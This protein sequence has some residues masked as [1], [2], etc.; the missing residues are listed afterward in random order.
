MAPILAYAD[1]TK[2]FKL[3]TDACGT[4]LGAVLYQTREDGT[5]AVIAYASRS[6]NKAESHYPAHK[7]EFLTLKWA[8]VEK[9]HE[10]LYGSTFDVHTDNNL[11][12]YILT[13]AKLDAASHHWVAS[14]A[15]YNFRLHYRSGKTNINADALSRVSWPECMPDNLGTSLKVNAAAIRAIQEAALDQ[16][17]CPIE[18]YSY[19]LHV[20][21]AIQDSQQVAQM[22]LDDWRQAQ[23]AD[24][25]LGT[26]IER[27]KA[28][29]LDQDWCKQTNSPKLN[30]F[31]RERNNL[32]LQ[33]G[34]LYRQA[35]P[36]ELDE[37]LLQLVLPPAYREVALKGCHDEVGHLGLEHMLDL[38]RD[39]FFWPHMAI[40]MK[41]HIG[42]CCPCLA[43]KARQPKAPLKNIMATHPLELVHLDFLCLEPGKGQEENVLVITDHFTRY[44]QAYVTRTQ[45]AP[46]MAKTLWDKFIVHYGLPKKILT[47][48][49]RNFK[50]QL[51]A[52]LCELMGVQKIWTSPY[53]LQTNGQCE[54]FNSTLI[55]ILG[56]L[57][58]EKK[59]EWKNHVGTLV[60][61]YNC[62]R[63]SATGFS[64]YY[65]MFGRQPHLPVDVALGLAP[66][67]IT[68]PNTAKFVQKL[69]EQNK[70]AHEKAKAFQ[71]KEAERHKRN[72][73]KKGRAVA[74]EV[75]DM[76]LV[77]VTAFK[78]R[79]KMQDRWENREY[80]VEKWPYPDLPVYV[81]CP[82]DG[83]GCS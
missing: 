11:L 15:N 80:V 14:L 63:N 25:A 56:T 50:S 33:K 65:L 2:P 34:I 8:V 72:Y 28:G 81:V 43:F 52:D 24:P 62:T 38:M 20:I 5:E 39:R 27:L 68:E 3:H 77:H 29:V 41:E 47:D 59:S 16:P 48:Q 70:W 19:D 83:E 1:F 13:T 67:T 30:Q 64:P 51:V 6:L 17:A 18:A 35:R 31:K 22:T 73:N 40:Q 66:C 4:G 78:G 61:V 9:F 44:T 60:R 42:K 82:R 21:G 49:G 10:Y 12:T 36:R 79:H 76:V 26:I 54:R 55:N 75:G 37:T 46:M 45:M 7:L 74:L 57:P 53:H 32:I 69:R 71:A 58:K 23:G